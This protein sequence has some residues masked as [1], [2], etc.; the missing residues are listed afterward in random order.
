MTRRVVRS[1]PGAEQSVT[2]RV[3]TALTSL[4]GTGSTRAVR[5]AAQQAL[6]DKQPTLSHIAALVATASSGATEAEQ[7]AAIQRLARILTGGLPEGV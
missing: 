4:S 3:V 7:V 5:E 6:E 1:Y 2:E